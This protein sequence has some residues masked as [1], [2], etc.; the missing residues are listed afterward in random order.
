MI[1]LDKWAVARAEQVQQQVV[2]AYERYEF[3]QIYQAVHYF[4]TVDMGG[5][6]L[7]II[8]DRQY[9]TQ[10]DSRARRSAQTAMYHIV[11]ALVRWLAPI[12]S[13]T[14]EEINEHVPGERPESLFLETWFAL[15]EVYPKEGVDQQM[16]LEYWSQVMHVRDA[17][18]KELEKARVAGVIGSS[19]DAEAELY[20]GREVLDRLAMLQDE[21][22]FVLITSYADIYEAGDPPKEATH[23]TLPSGDE[24]WVAVKASQYRK[25]TRCWHRREDVGADTRHPELCGRCVE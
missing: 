6:Y 21:L 10:T 22:R 16:N 23:F 1:E 3:H 12:L 11:E 20:C 5:F 7:D 2:G 13:F 15:P 18:Y 19:L 17:V 24:I 25:C 9:T 4:C 8:K 14:A